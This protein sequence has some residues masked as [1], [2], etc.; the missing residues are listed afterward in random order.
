MGMYIF[1]F[2]YANYTNDIR[3]CLITQNF[4]ENNKQDIQIHLVNNIKGKISTSRYEFN[5]S[6]IDLLIYWIYQF[7]FKDNIFIL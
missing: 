2:S 4:H 5:W 3:Y 1:Y 7:K 6:N